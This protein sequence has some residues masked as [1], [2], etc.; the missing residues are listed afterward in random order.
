MIVRIVKMNFKENRVQ[1]FLA[2]FN[3]V[4]VN[5]RQFPGCLHLE[6]WRDVKHPN[7]MF[8][9]SKWDEQKSLQAYR[10][11]ALFSAT[12]SKT[13]AMFAEKAEARSLQPHEF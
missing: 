10:R 5:I 13:K 6:L 9:Y 7:V 3:E 12:W 8:T 4:R 1:D 11:S 2:L